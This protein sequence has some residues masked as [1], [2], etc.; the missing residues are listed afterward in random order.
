MI[1][2]LKDDDKV[3]CPVCKCIQSKPANHFVTVGKTDKESRF[4]ELCEYCDK[5]FISERM[6]D[7]GIRIAF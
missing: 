2:F 1:V 4:E 7:G 6:P 5:L 3:V